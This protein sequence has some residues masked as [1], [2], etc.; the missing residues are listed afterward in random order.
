VKCISPRELLEGLQHLPGNPALVVLAPVPSNHPLLA[1]VPAHARVLIEPI[2]PD[3]IVATVESLAPSHIYRSKIAMNLVRRAAVG[4]LAL[5]YMIEVRNC[6]ALRRSN[7]C[8]SRSGTGDPYSDCPVSP[9]NGGAGK[10]EI[11]LRIQLENT[12]GPTEPTDPTGPTK[13]SPPATGALE[14]EL[15][16][17]YDKDADTDRA[18]HA[19]ALGDLYT[20][21][22]SALRQQGGTSGGFRKALG[23]K[24]S[25]L[26]PTDVLLPLRQRVATE[27]RTVLPKPAD[28][29]LDDATRE[30]AAKLFDRL[31]AAMNSITSR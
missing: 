15:A 3:E 9:S 18:K 14:K 10:Q 8:P 22:A 19:K 29:Q 28:T 25:Q 16:D 26:L 27:L 23:T 5:A 30:A 2:D 21:A 24:S 20:W 11:I 13:P 4:I 31:A 6:P 7:S 12:T 1:D 17:L